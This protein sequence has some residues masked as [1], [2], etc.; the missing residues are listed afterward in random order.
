M[1]LA[2]TLLFTLN[3][4]RNLSHK[5][6]RKAQFR[7]II[8]T[9][10]RDFFSVGAGFAR[11]FVTKQSHCLLKHP[12]LAVKMPRSLAVPLLT[13]EIQKVEIS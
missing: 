7:P 13:L 3:L 1:T 4:Y 6:A 2:L 5:K 12:S 11:R 10:I 8:L 9:R